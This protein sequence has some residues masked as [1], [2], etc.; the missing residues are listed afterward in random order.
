MI[1][2]LVGSPDEL[3]TAE[4]FYAYERFASLVQEKFEDQTFLRSV[5]AFIDELALSGDPLLE[6]VLTVGLLERLAERPTVTAALKPYVGAKASDLLKRME[7][8][9]FGRA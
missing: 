9:I 1:L 8:E 6:N 7:R 5:G 3:N 4:P 2:Q